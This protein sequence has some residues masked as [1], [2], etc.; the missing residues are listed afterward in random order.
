MDVRAE[1]R[2]FIKKNY[3]AAGDSFDDNTPL[4]EKGIVDSF[5]FLELLTFI[6]QRFSVE[7]S[8]A[9]L[10]EENSDTIDFLAKHIIS[11]VPE[12]KNL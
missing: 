1:L 3:V 12:D 10:Q 11:L 7:I 5:G 6:Q 2:N 8:D 9:V 4:I